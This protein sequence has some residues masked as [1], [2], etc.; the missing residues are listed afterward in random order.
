VA[1]QPFACL[2]DAALVFAC[3][4][5][6][7]TASFAASTA[8]LESFYAS[9]SAALHPFG[10]SAGAHNF[11]PILPVPGHHYPLGGKAEAL[12]LLGGAPVERIVFGE[13]VHKLTLGGAEVA[14]IFLG[15]PP[16]RKKTV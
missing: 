12:R 14:P 5:S 4:G 3:T 11:S 6:A 2:A 15:G 16:A 7:S 13:R 9:G 10:C 1:V 8:A